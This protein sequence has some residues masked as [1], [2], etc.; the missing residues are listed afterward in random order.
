MLAFDGSN[1]AIASSH[2]LGVAFNEGHYAGNVAGKDGLFSGTAA[3]DISI[4]VRLEGLSAGSYELYLVGRNT[5]TI[6]LRTMDVFVSVLDAG[7]NAYD[8]S[9]AESKAI[10]NDLTSNSASQWQ[11]GHDYV[12]WAVDIA[13]GESLFIAF[14]GRDGS[15]DSR[16]FMNSIQIVQVPEPS[17]VA[18]LGGIACLGAAVYVRQRRRL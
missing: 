2:A 4:G 7:T 11:E 15:N 12:A 18:L 3:Q 17:S 16:G 10:L 14:D 8:F 5:N 9:G 1:G 6:Q 13:E